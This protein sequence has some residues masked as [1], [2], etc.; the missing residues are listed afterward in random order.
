MTPKDNN[1]NGITVEVGGKVIGKIKEWKPQ[2][3]IPE[4]LTIPGIDFLPPISKFDEFVKTIHLR[5]SRTWC[6]VLRAIGREDE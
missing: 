5:V 6:D 4:K 2:K 1:F 3:E